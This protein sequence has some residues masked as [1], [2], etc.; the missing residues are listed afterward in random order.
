MKAI[1]SVWFDEEAEGVRDVK[2][3]KA[4]AKAAGYRVA[5]VCEVAIAFTKSVKSP[6]NKWQAMDVA[7][8]A[9]FFAD[10]TL[11]DAGFKPTDMLWSIGEG[12]VWSGVEY[13]ID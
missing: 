9:Y 4:A 7:Q 1:F 6:A 3:V 8:A 12:D 2:A 5:K 10:K 13:W 11:R